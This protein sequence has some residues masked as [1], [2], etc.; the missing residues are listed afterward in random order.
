MHEHMPIS[1]HRRRGSMALVWM[2]AAVTTLFA[3]IWFISSVPA[4]AQDREVQF[5]KRQLTEEFYSEGAAFADINNDGAVDLVVGPYWFEGPTFRE[6]HAYRTPEVANIYG[7]SKFFL[8][9]THDINGDGWED[10]LV[11]DEPNAHAYWYENPQGG[12]GLWK[13]HLAH[14]NIGNES[15]TLTDVDGDGHPDLVFQ[16]NGQLGFAEYDP[17][18]PTKQWAFHPISPPRN[19]S[20]YAHGLGVGDVN[21][22]GRMD[23]LEEDGWWEQPESLDQPWI[24]HYF[25]FNTRGPHGGAQM[26]VYDVDGDGLGDVITSLDGHHWGLAWF[27]QIRDGGQIT[28]KENLIMGEHPHEVPYHDVTFSQVHAI[29]LEDVDGDGL[30]DIITGKRRWAHGPSGDPEPNAPPVLYWFKLHRTDDGGAWFEPHFIDDASGTGTQ[31]TAGDFN[32]LGT[33]DILVA[34]KMGTYVFFQLP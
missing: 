24:H 28:F 3:G 32:N 25:N 10:I 33:L 4:A 31:F 14:P 19:R 18:N 26:Y 29:V 20:Y 16:Y 27:K 5:I 22:D 2:L 15:P 17:D 11:I 30:L 21:G 23:V 12:E 9:F 6:R 13:A 34:N 1:D 7:Y 8:I